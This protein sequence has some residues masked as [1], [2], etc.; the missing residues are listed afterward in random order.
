MKIAYFGSPIISATLLERLIS[1]GIKPDLIVTQKDKPVGKKLEITPTAVKKVARVHNIKIFD[2][3]I[4][5]NS[6]GELIQNIREEG[7]ELCI[8]FAFGKIIS[9]KLLNSVKYGFWNVHPSLLPKYRGPAPIIYPMLLGE[10]KTGTTL[11]QMNDKLDEGDVIVQN[12]IEI[13]TNEKIKDLEK[14]IVDISCKQILSSINNLKK[15]KVY[16]EKQKHA[17]ATYTRLISKNDG[18]IAPLFL[19]RAQNGQKIEPQEFPN[20]VLDY[21][22]DN[23]LNIPKSLESQKLLFN[24][25]RS[26]S[27]WPGLW[28]E[29]KIGEKSVR[30]KITK[31]NLVENHLK[32]E[33]MQVAGKKEVEYST[34]IKSYRI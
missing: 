3:S 24:M 33:N 29:S 32:I 8:L 12:N 9:S 10:E 19:K 1:K 18:Y 15:G 17:N 28:T 13:N 22:K 34:F 20:I 4:N 14:K 16:S 26:L 5:K 11:M 31:M 23:N 2:K 25:Y 30:T 21:Y 6:E 7:I 27:P